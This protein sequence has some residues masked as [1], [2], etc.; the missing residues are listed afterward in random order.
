MEWRPLCL[1]WP[2]SL[3]N[4]YDQPHHFLPLPVFQMSFYQIKQ[5]NRSNG[6]TPAHAWTVFSDVSG[7]CCLRTQLPSHGKQSAL[8]VIWPNVQSH[9]NW[10]KTMNLPHWTI[11]FNQLTTNSSLQYYWPVVKATYSCT[12]KEKVKVLGCG[13]F[14]DASPIAPAH[15]AAHARLRIR[16]ELPVSTLENKWIDYCWVEFLPWQILVSNWL[17]LH[18]LYSCILH[19]QQISHW[20]SGWLTLTADNS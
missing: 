5:T 9:W 20:P 1:P 8:H 6:L 16:L 17:K 14:Q 4:R 13:C 11:I 19:L 7:S 15:V 3:L 12:G 2:L 10:Q 18:C